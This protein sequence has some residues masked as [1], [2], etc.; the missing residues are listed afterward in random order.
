MQ[1]QQDHKYTQNEGNQRANIAFMEGWETSRWCLC[2]GRMGANICVF[3]LFEMTQI[4][5]VVCT[6]WEHEYFES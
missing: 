2:D 1:T 4:W 5:T 6:I 3:N